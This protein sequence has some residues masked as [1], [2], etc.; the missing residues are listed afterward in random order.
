M[1]QSSVLALLANGA[2]EIWFS[3]QDHKASLIRIQTAQAEDAAG[4]IEQ[5]VT[6]IEGQ[7][8]WTTQL[9]WSG[10]TLDQ[11]RFDALRL[12]RQVPAITEFAE[13][14]R[15][16]PRAA[17]GFAARA[18]RGRQRYR[19]LQGID[20]HRSRC[21]QSLL[22]AGLLPPRIRAHMTLSLTGP[23]RDAGVSVA[24]VN[25]KLIWDVVSKIKV[26]QRGRAY[27]VDADG[28]LIAHPN[29]NLV[30]RNTDMS[31]LAQ[32]RS[33]RAAQLA[34]TSSRCRKRWIFRATRC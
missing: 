18:R 2:F 19:R 8:G 15:L 25:L 28:R 29:N 33:A 24:E 7:I 23:R 21:A 30:L 11:R 31:R 14:D 22:R 26:G 16:R 32:V 6:E 10:D 20:I 13:I 5:F 34:M 4:K 12:L 3:Y 9:P 27:V 17:A 1:S